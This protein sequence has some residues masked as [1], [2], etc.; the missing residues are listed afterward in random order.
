MESV[1]KKKERERLTIMTKLANARNSSG[2]TAN[3]EN[4]QDHLRGNATMHTHEHRPF[5]VLV[6]ITGTVLI[7]MK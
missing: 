1:E 7:A 4:G 6:H 3:E 5:R 2:P